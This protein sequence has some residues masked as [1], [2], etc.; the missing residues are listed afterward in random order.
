MAALSVGAASS[1]KMQQRACGG[2]GVSC[3]L[4][5]ISQ[6]AYADSKQPNG[7]VVTTQGMSALTLPSAEW[8]QL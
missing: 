1:D 4:I 8:C 3:M 7:A 5:Q 2:L 6:M